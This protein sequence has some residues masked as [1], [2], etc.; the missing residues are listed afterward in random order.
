[1]AQKILNASID[2]KFVS[3]A[4]EVKPTSAEGSGE[5]SWFLMIQVRFTAQV[6]NGHVSTRGSDSKYRGRGI[7]KTDNRNVHLI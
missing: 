1:L 4:D 5:E 2:G 7:S 6:Q 3:R